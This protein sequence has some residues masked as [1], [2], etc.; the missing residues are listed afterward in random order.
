MILAGDI[1]GTNSRLAIYDAELNKRHEAVTKNQGRAG[2]SGIV[3]EFLAAAPA[4]LR[5]IDRACFGVAGPVA[6]GR[7]T[8]TNLTWHLDERTLSAELGVPKVALINDLVAHAE[9]IEVLKPQHFL[10]IHAGEPVARGNRAVIAA[11][12][13]L[14]EAGLVWEPGISGYRAFASEGGHADFCP[15]TDRDV[16]LLRYVQQ[17]KGLAT[18]E[19]VLSGPGLRRIYDFLITPAQL[20]PSAAMPGPDPT[21]E[22]I[23]AAAADRSSRAAVEAM[24]TF[25]RFYGSE[26]GNLAL[27]L[28]ANGGIYL[29]GGIAIGIVEQLRSPLFLDA[30]HDKGPDKLRAVIAKMPVYL[31]TYEKCALAGAANFARRL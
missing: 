14:G 27:K 31:V 6:N 7:V 18:W 9:G 30:L 25:V 1:G 17:T 5:R 21:P 10:T 22:A 19:R 28:L 13:G 2:L 4:E 26:S 20:G 15:R 29:S 16:A 24:E 3:R 11:G 23:A 12:T 8:P